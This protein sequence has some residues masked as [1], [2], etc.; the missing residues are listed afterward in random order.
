MVPHTH[1]FNGNIFHYAGMPEVT[2]YFALKAS[3][4]D[5]TL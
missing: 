1:V 4:A 2:H 5:F 3:F